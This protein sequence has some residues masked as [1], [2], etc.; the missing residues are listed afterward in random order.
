[1]ANSEINSVDPEGSVENLKVK[2][3]RNLV[4]VEQRKSR[5][6]KKLMNITILHKTVC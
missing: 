1:M 5:V 2:I 6:Q 4:V 3:I